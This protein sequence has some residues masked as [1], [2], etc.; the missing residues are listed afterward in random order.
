MVSCV[1]LLVLPTIVCV[2]VDFASGGKFGEGL[3]TLAVSE[4]EGWPDTRTFMEQYVLPMKPVAM[5]GAVAAS[6]AARLWRTDEYFLSLET[7]NHVDSIMVET[8]KKESRQQRME[9]LALKEFIRTYN[10]S[11]Y[12]MV[13]AVP[14]SRPT[15]GQRW[16][17]TL[18]QHWQRTLGQC[19]FARWPLVGPTC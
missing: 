1:L 14:D 12:Y 6:K 2:S 13:N 17:F 11:G 7:G 4:I 5:R 3:P 19:H 8:E 15:L 10:Q 9:T 16:H 18:G